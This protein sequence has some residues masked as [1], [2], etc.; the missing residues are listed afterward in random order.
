[1]KPNMKCPNCNKPI[2]GIID[3]TIKGHPKVLLFKD[4]E[5]M[6]RYMESENDLPKSN[7]RKG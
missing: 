3:E 7:G 2:Y 4:Q 5:A 6:I 1:M